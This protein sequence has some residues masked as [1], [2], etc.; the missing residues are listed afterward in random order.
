MPVII[1]STGKAVPARHCTN[2]ELPAEL[3][4]SDEWIYSHTGIKARY[5]AGEGD[6]AVS[7][8]TEA[9]RKVLA[10]AGVTPDQVGLL[11]CSTTTPAYIGL[12]STACLIQEQTGAVNATCFDLTAA[13]SGFVY[14]VNTAVGMMECNQLDYALIV[15]TEVLSG[16][17][18]WTDR[19][20]CV[21]FGDAAGAVLLQRVSDA[22]AAGAGIGPFVSGSDGSG[23]MALFLNEKGFIQMDGHA[24]YD[25]A[26]ASM[27]K[28]IRDLMEK[29]HL[30]ESD[31]DYFVCHQANERI[32]KASAKRLGYDFD[33]FVRKMGDYGNTSSASI[34]VALADMDAEGKLTKGTVV[35]LAAFGAG[36]TWGGAV[37]R[38]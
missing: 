7:L 2:A 11:L 19:S 24:V 13:C 16:I 31:V 22:E 6:T 30:T 34:P 14:A 5:L 9:C 4:T 15:S 28:I 26:V 20:T 25:F 8:G 37:L 35:V 27:T 36:L 17:C 23:A 1:R 38:F 10:K 3:G 33:K 29:E 32:L 12:P 21:L 18:D